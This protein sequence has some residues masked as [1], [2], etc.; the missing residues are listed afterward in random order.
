MKYAKSMYF[1]GDIVFADECNYQSAQKLG[2]KCPFC[3]S[4]VF[5]RSESVRN[6]KGKLQ[7]ISPY[8][9]HYSSGYLNN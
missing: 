4:A 2:L 7:L 8:F 5:L 3:D 9:A 6:V 1:G